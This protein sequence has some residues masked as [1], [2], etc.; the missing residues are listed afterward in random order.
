MPRLLQFGATGQLARAVVERAPGRGARLH[1]LSRDDV[2]L[3]RPEDARRA[4]EAAPDFDVAVIAAAYTAVDAAEDAEDEAFAV[5]AASP[6]AIAEACAARGAAIVYVSTDYVF[7]G[8]KS[9]PYVEDDPPA[10][11]NAYGRTKL[12][13]ERAVMAANPRSVVVRTSWL[14]APY[15]RN[16]VT[17]MVRLGRERARLDVVDD[18][19]GA[20]TAAGD[21]ANA[22]LTLA[23]A[24][25]QDRANAWGVLHYAGAGATS[26]AGFAQAVFALAG[27]ALA[28]HPPQIAPIPSSAYPTKAAR[29]ANSVLSCARIT[30][31]YGARPRPWREALDETLKQMAKA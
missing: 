15:G 10:P 31:A 8:S 28:P 22:L 9:G 16:F 13:G 11:I 1:A 2:D 21:L 29:P 3:R 12:A 24:I 5:N 18:Q 20:P 26:W 30:Q 23:D 7:D 14:Y 27:P 4:V 6:G 19:R 25:A 17:T